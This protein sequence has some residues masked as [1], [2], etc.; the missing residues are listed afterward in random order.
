MLLQMDKTYSMSL[1]KSYMLKQMLAL[2]NRSGI[3]QLKHAVIRS[4]FFFFLLITEHT[5]M[6]YSLIIPGLHLVPRDVHF[7]LSK[8]APFEKI[9]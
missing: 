8:W 5:I 9:S 2:S 1:F 7:S 3:K 6:F 4:I